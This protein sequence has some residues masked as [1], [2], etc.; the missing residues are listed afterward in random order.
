MSVTEQI[1]YL[2]GQ[3]PESEKYLLL[4]IIKR[5]VPDDLATPDDLEA[6]QKARKELK[7]GETTGHNEINWR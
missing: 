3:L 6:I 5:F 2:L 4:E 7:R 1:D